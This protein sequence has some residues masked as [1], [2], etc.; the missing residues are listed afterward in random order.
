MAFADIGC[1]VVFALTKLISLGHLILFPNLTNIKDTTNLTYNNITAN[2]SWWIQSLYPSITPTN[3]TMTAAVGRK[4]FLTCIFL[5]AWITFGYCD[6]QSCPQKCLCGKTTVDCS[7]KG[8][9]SVP[10]DLDREIEVL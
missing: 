2:S 6:L 7:F 8:L 1:C 3:G 5:I 4:H 9:T 10:K